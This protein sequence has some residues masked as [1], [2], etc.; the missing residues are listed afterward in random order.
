[1]DFQVG[2]IKTLFDLPNK[3]AQ[4]HSSQRER[5]RER[6]CYTLNYFDPVGWNAGLGAVDYRPIY[7]TTK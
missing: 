6:D 1:M 3:K 4:K 7:N 5:E 2:H